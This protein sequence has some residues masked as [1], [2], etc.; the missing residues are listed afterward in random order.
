M[1]IW[2]GNRL[3]LAAPADPEYLR[4][5]PRAILMSAGQAFGTGTHPTSQMCLVELQA[6]LQDGDRVLDVG[7]GSGILAIAAARLGAGTVV[8][9]DKSIPACRVAHA[10]VS[11]N[12][13]A[14]L[15]TV[16]VG[17]PEV[18]G[19]GARFDLVLA[20]LDTAADAAYW[21]P[22]LSRLC[23]GGGKIVL[24]GF[25]LPGEG[26]VQQALEE[27]HLARLTRRTQEGWITLVLGKPA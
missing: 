11:R 3:I 9:I 12:E 23:R 27:A 1:A 5:D 10:N 21:L 17:S 20:N 19:P 13:L 4:Q 24:S 25:Q 22:T 7:T 14:K 15:V 26:R 18:L 2:I 8:A 6:N 16:I